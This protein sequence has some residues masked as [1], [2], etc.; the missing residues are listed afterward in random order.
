MSELLAAS[1]AQPRFRSML[2]LTFA[3]IAAVLALVGIYG[4]VAFIVNQR[5][6]EIGVRLALGAQ[7]RDVL[8]LVM[9]QGATPIVA[10]I[11]IGLAGGVGIGRAMRSLLFEVTATDLAT[12]VLVPILL[13][14]VALVAILIPARRAMKVQPATALR[15]D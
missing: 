6:H 4:V 12:F 5:A 7:R 8:S 14:L 11:V 15:A 3:V 13:A 9:R 1:V 10:G 2:L